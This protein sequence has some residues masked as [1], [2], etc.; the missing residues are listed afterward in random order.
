M[1]TGAAVST[2]V[3]TPVFGPMVA[4]LSGRI[5]A[6]VHQPLLVLLGVGGL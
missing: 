4:S 2:L 6:L 5:G 3:A 1:D